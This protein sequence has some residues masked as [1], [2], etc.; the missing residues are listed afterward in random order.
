MRH[1]LIL[2]LLFTTFTA[3]GQNPNDRRLVQFSGV[4]VTGD[5]L[6]PVPFTS[7]LTR[8]S[9]R[10]TISDVY[11]YYSFVAQAG[12]TLEFA[13][14]GFKRGNYIIPDTL[15]ESKYS[16]IHVLFPDTMLLRPVDVYPWPSREQFRD[17]FLALNLSD[18][19]YQRVLKHLN[20][21]EAIQRMENLPPD[22][23]LAAHYQSALDNT[24]IYNQGMAPTINL[25]NP[26]AWAQFVQ[27]WKA[28]SLKKQ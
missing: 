13:A 28:G 2:L 18:N 10:G 9:Y 20:S 7:I 3:F 17:A 24:R 27:A 4:V 19:E 15:S 25:F 6:E 23:G 21:A 5:S 1:L 12:D 14:V 22:A 16:M 11:G 8:G 26:I